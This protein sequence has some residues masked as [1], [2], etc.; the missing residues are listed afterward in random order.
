MIKQ[1]VF[2]QRSG[3]VGFL[4]VR[5]H[6]FGAAQV[7]RPFA[8]HLERARAQDRNTRQPGR[9]ERRAG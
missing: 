5:A 9:G 7:R 4:Q 6:E 3:E 8:K 1:G 2:Q